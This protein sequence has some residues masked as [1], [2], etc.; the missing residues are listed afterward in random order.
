MQATDYSLGY[1][2]AVLGFMSERTANIH[3]AFFLTHLQPGWRPRR[4]LRTRHH[5]AWPGEGRSA[6]T[7]DGH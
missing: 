7:C 6:G 2:D 5:H 3:A 1:S 4:R